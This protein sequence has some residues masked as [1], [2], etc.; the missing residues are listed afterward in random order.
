[1]RVSYV[2]L[3]KLLLYCNDCLKQLYI[4]KKTEQFR[5]KDRCRVYRHAYTE[6]FKSGLGLGYR[7]MALGYE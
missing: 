6:A 3:Y 1:M 2:A 4:S 7:Q 5:Y